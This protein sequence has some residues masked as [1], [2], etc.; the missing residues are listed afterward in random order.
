MCGLLDYP[1]RLV[2]IAAVTPLSV[3]Q[4]ER[5]SMVLLSLS[6]F[7]EKIWWK[8]VPSICPPLLLIADIATKNWCLV[9]HWPGKV[10]S[11][12]AGMAAA[13]QG[14]TDTGQPPPSSIVRT[15]YL[16]S[17]S[18]LLPST[19]WKNSYYRTLRLGDFSAG[20]LLT[21]LNTDPEV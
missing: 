8:G 4:R 17:P 18:P 16:V 2:R 1:P 7:D 11:V 21:W 9:D 13:P 19:L 6:R 3:P 12:V 10:W 20:L 5:L 14:S 15:R